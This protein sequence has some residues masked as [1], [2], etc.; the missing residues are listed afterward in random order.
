MTIVQPDFSIIPLSRKAIEERL[1][2]AGSMCLLD[3]ITAVNKQ[4]LTACAISHQDKLNPLMLDGK[5]AT[6]NGVEYAAQAMA[7]HGSFLS[8]KTQSGYIATVRN[9]ELFTP[10]LP[11]NNLPLI[12]NV[13][14]LM[15]D[16][17]GF[18]YQFQIQCKQQNIISG[19]ITIFLMPS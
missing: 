12:I 5:I 19:K 10:Y 7:V 6:I 2:H 1:P 15:S 3:E 8:E 14:Q 11:Q 18:T 17:N 4:T 16:K 13:E 9:I